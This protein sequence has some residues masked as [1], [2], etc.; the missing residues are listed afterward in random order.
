M[1]HC[2]TLRQIPSSNRI[3]NQ[4]SQEGG[5]CAILYRKIGGAI[6]LQ[7]AV[8]QPS[9]RYVTLLDIIYHVIVYVSSNIYY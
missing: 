3:I 5:V 1:Q 6:F 9:N 4:I 2:P 7:R 8:N